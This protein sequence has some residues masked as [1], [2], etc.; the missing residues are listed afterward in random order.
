[1]PAPNDDLHAYGWDLKNI[2]HPDPKSLDKKDPDA[3]KPI[4]SAPQET[5]KTMLRYGHDAQFVCPKYLQ[6]LLDQSPE[7]RDAVIKAGENRYRIEDIDKLEAAINKIFTEVVVADIAK[8]FKNVAR[9]VAQFY[10]ARLA[11]IK[12]FGSESG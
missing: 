11:H 5:M 1:M 12:K 4:F 2:R 9:Q 7:L 6:I 3:G 10:A 8:N